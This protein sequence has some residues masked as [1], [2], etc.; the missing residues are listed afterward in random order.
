MT[1]IAWRD[2]VLA[3]DSQATGGNVKSRCAKLFQLG[4]GRIVG[5]AGDY[6]RGC[7]FVEALKRGEPIKTNMKGVCALVLAGDGTVTEYDDSPHP[8]P[9]I[10][11]FY[12]IGSGRMAAMAAMTCGKSAL[13]AVHVA[14]EIDC[15]TSG[16][17]VCYSVLQLPDGGQQ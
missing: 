10:D 15:Y 1:T 16:P 5:I 9:V 7:A 14:A 3:S 12:A 13:E 6:A 2:G 4:D 17:F 8:M 11:S